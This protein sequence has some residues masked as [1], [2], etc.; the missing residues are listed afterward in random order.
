M[1]R[2]KQVIFNGYK[3]KKMALSCSKEVISIIKRNNIKNN[4]NFFC[5]NYL[6][7]FRTQ[8]NTKNLIKHRL[9]FMQILNV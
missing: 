9:L 7:S 5:S 3:R 8:N 6:H 2:E 1:Y 4:D